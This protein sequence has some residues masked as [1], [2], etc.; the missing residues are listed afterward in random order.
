MIVESKYCKLH[1]SG[2]VDVSE[3]CVRICLFKSATVNYMVLGAFVSQGHA[4]C[5]VF[6]SASEMLV[7]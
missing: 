6:S 3:H 1:G 2:T 4:F 7:A 5:N